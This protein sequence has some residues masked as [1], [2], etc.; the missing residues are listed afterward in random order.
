MSEP[1]PPTRERASRVD[2]IRGA[3][4]R[5]SALREGLRT[6]NATAVTTTAGAF[7]T[8]VAE[9]LER[10]RVVLEIH[11]DHLSFDGNDVLGGDLVAEALLNGWEQEGLVAVTIEPS[12]PEPELRELGLLLGRDW[13]GRSTDEEDLEAVVWKGDFDN[14]HFR[15]VGRSVIT[16]ADVETPSVEEIGVRLVHQLGLAGL[17]DATVRA[18][19]GALL[20]QLSVAELGPA[21]QG[22]AELR[23]HVS[24]RVATAQLARM[25]RDADVTLDTVARCLL[26]TVRGARTTEAARSTTRHLA[27]HVQSQL[28]RGE[29]ERAIALLRRLLVLTTPDLFPQYRFKAVVSAELRTLWRAEGQQAM[30]HGIAAHGDPA[31]WK[32]PL[33]TLGEIAQ[34][35]DLLDLCTFGAQVQASL[36]QPLADALLLLADRSGTTLR[37]LLH[38]ANET[39]LPV[40]LLATRRRPD[41]TL[42]EP[43]LARVGSASPQVRE[44]VLLALRDHQSPRI[45]QVMRD[46]LADPAKPVRLE[47]LRYLT[48]YRDKEGG[49]AALRRLEGARS[50]PRL[51]DEELRG[52]GIAVAIILRDDGVKALSKLAD[53]A[54]SAAAKEQEAGRRGQASDVVTGALHGLRAAGAPGRAALEAVGRTHPALRGEI[55]AILG[56]TR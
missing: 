29:P 52:L 3:M 15:F 32:G 24:N 5:L 42:V 56:G 10:G 41:P 14:V 54:Y 25:E 34:A 21:P 44:A 8:Q 55:R 43:L 9:A 19:V 40:I 28:Q 50:G 7:A 48:V 20:E 16:E 23:D 35:E 22:L 26:E 1:T 11:P 53:A 51:E 33:F 6:E 49:E 45:K 2:L 13:R 38:D 12:T 30:L 27:R 4:N 39:A 46:G 31:A 37:Q 17:D 36:R 18:D 47:A